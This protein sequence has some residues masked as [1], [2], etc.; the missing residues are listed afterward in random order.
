MSNSSNIK[1][2]TSRKVSVFEQISKIEKQKKLGRSYLHNFGQQKTISYPAS[3]N[4]S[5]KPDY[6][7]MSNTSRQAPKIQLKIP[8]K[9][10]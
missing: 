7:T 10:E 5:Y 2:A 4:L 6:E 3:P 1:D 8:V 9:P